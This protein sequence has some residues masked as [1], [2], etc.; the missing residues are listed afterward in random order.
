MDKLKSASALIDRFERES[1]L[2]PAEAEKM[3]SEILRACGHKVTD[4]GFV[5]GDQR[6]DCFFEADIDGRRQRI[7]VEVKFTKAPLGLSQSVEQAFRLKERGFFDRA[8]VISRAGFSPLAIIQA[9]TRGLG[10]ID[11]FTPSDLRSWLSKQRQPRETDQQSCMLIIRQAMQKLAHRLA[12]HPEELMTVEWRDLERLLCEAFEGIGFET[13]LTRSGKDG[14]F[15]LELTTYD[16][17]KRRSYLVE[18]KHWTDQKPGAGHL[19]KLIKVAVQQNAAGGLLLSTSGFTKT[20][21]R[22]VMEISAPIRLG[23]GKKVLSL[24]RVYYRLGSELWLPARDLQETLFS[25]TQAIP[26]S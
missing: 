18:V 13:S 15:D 1:T 9:E 10:Q 23:D 16:A 12:L 14:G 24:C 26:S 25:D 17:G 22:G 5:G 21:Y 6:V 19:K 4:Q 20:V 3:V 11:L 8:M 2:L 7:A